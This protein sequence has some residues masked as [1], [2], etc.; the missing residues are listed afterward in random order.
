MFDN[1]EESENIFFS[2]LCNNILGAIMLDNIENSMDKQ[3]CPVCT[4]SDIETQD[5]LAIGFCKVCNVQFTLNSP[6]T[7]CSYSTNV[8][9][10]YATG[11][12]ISAGTIVISPM[13]GIFSPPTSF[14]IPNDPFCYG[15]VISTEETFKPKTKCPDC[16]GSKVYVGLNKTEPCSA[17]KGLGEI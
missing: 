11:G 13:A 14:T 7:A 12:T 17:C 15:G 1:I 9:K 5:A 2:P 16:K 3:C 6:F 4:N 10:P 8:P